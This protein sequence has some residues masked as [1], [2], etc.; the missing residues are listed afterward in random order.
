MATTTQQE[1]TSGALNGMPAPK[2]KTIDGLNIRYVQNDKQ[3]GDDILLLC[4]WPESIYAFLPTW[5]T[6]SSLGRVTAM[7]LPGFGLS[8]YRQEVMAPEAMGEFLIRV[9]KG[10]ALN[11]P[12]VCAPD[13][14]SPA[15][16]YASANH[17]GTFK[18]MI[19][20]SGAFEV[21]DIGNILDT[22][23]NAPDLAPYKDW[24]GERFVEGATTDI[25]KYA[26]PAEVK[27]DYLA[28]Q[29]GERFWASISF[30]RDYPQSLPRLAARLK[31]VID[32]VQITVGEHD[33]FVHV[34]SMRKLAKGLPKC[35]IDVLDGNHFVW[36]DCAAEYGS[37][38]A[39]WI[40]GGYAKI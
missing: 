13:V 37:I 12:H 34:A 14:G 7:D 24:T 20:G 16:L 29:H 39:E 36:E 25:V 26:V 35:K 5:E 23:V 40:K 32:P 4:P 15:V 3:D 11:K 30:V 28:G 21:T 9:V 33:V 19:L 8:E 31:D 22:F 1:K 6:F 18:S 17:P 2:W 10:F 38:A 27:K